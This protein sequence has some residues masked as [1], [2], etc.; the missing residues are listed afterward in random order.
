M[1]RNSNFTGLT[2]AQVKSMIQARLETKRIVQTSAGTGSTSGAIIY[3][4]AIAQGDAL[5]QRSGDKVLIKELNWTF[6]YS[7]SVT[8]TSRMMLVQD[9]LNVGAA[10]AVTDILSSATVQA[11]LSPANHL[12]NRFKVLVDETFETSVAGIQYINKRGSVKVKHPVYYNGTGTA[13]TDGG[14]GSLYFLIVNGQA[15]GGYVI[16]VDTGY[17]DA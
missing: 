5:N 1:R 3:Y 12:Q 17:T 9:L 13:S 6:A 15:T 7:D 14:R 2:K 8:G 10:P 16:N 4:S 11:H